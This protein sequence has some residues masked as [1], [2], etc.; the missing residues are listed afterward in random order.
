MPPLNSTPTEA[1]SIYFDAEEFDGGDSKANDDD[2]ETESQYEDVIELSD[3]D[4]VDLDASDV[5]VD[6]DDDVLNTTVIDE[7]SP[8]VSSQKTKKHRRYRRRRQISGGE[9]G[10][11]ETTAESA[12]VKQRVRALKL[13]YIKQKLVDFQFYR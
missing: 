4:E 8:P 6:H 10:V 13:L 2:T 7:P 3:I 9:K 12:A 1:P 11:E 5:T